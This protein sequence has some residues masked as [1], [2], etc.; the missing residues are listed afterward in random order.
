M[1]T[2][3]SKGTGL[4]LEIAIFSHLEAHVR[5]GFDTA[6]ATV[7]DLLTLLE[8]RIRE[9]EERKMAYAVGLAATCGWDSEALAYIAGGDRGQAPS[10][11]FAHRLLLPYLIDLHVGTLAYNRSDERLVS[12]ASL[13]S[14]RLFAEEVQKVMA[15]VEEYM[16]AAIPGSLAATEVVHTLEIEEPV[17]MEAFRRLAGDGEGRFRLY[18]IPGLGWVL[19]RC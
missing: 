15:Y 12:L 7:D 18:E 10:P 6:P 14:P 17:V 4:I 3:R 1:P 19:A 16:R 9:A 13:F 11:P 2:E 8:P 5:E